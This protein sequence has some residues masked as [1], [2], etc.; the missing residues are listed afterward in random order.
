MSNKHLKREDVF[1]KLNIW[2]LKMFSSSLRN[3]SCTSRAPASGGVPAGWGASPPSPPLLEQKDSV[4]LR[5]TPLQFPLG[6]S[7]PP[8]PLELRRMLTQPSPLPRPL[9]LHR[10]LLGPDHWPPFGR[11]DQI[12][13]YRNP[14]YRNPREFWRARQKFQTVTNRQRSPFIMARSKLPSSS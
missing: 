3:Y 12:L 1:F 8:R 5:R 4:R 13:T 9:E 10:I 14:A 11:M 2:T 6:C 7:P